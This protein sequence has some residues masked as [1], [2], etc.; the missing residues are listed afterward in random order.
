MVK[1]S[2]GKDCSYILFGIAIQGKHL[3]DNRNTNKS[4][5]K[6]ED[7]N[8]INKGNLLLDINGW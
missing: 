6:K 4:S 8:Y 5:N 3:L 2:K 1:R 7:D